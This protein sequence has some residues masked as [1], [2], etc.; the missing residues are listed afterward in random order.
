MINQQLKDLI[1]PETIKSYAKACV[2]IGLLLPQLFDSGYQIIVIPSRGAYPF[3][4][5]ANST[6]W[7]WNNASKKLHYDYHSK[8]R[9]WLL[10]FTSDFGDTSLKIESSN[11]RRFWSRV[12]SDFIKGNDSIY[13]RYYETLVEEL[14][15]KLMIN[16]SELLLKKE[17]SNHK[18]TD[19]R[20]IFIDTVI[21]GRAICEIIQAFK[22]CNLQD[23][24]II[25]VIDENGNR[26]K[27]EYKKILNEEEAHGRLK[28]F[29]V[30]KIFSEDASPLLNSG[31][32]SIV[33]PSLMERTFFEI[34]EFRDNN[35]VGAGLWF[36]DS[37]SHLKDK[38]PTLN[39]VRG[40][41]SVLIF[42][43]IQ[44]QLYSKEIF[45]DEFVR[46]SAEEMISDLGSINLFN[47]ESTVD[48]I[49][50]RIRRDTQITE[51]VT[52]TNSHVVRI[53][54]HQNDITTIVERF[55]KMNSL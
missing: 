24:Y 1:T 10:P 13:K 46:H 22:D 29:Y 21:S 32:A 18:K 30:D 35:I 33:F 44:Q 45:F 6:N 28:S 8:H 25:A 12:L 2:D 20:F 37:I 15:T 54:L 47:G 48:L 50:N 7:L 39:G 19:Q 11:I 17:L 38:N 9:I 34:K 55:R 49:Y 51:K 14:G 3:Y 53:D 42:A 43:S 52:A 31:I 4:Y 26:L 36:I 23:Y 40:T 27:N 5:G 41:L 16:T